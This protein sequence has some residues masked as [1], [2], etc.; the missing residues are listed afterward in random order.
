MK[1]RHPASH[2]WWQNCY[3]ANNR[4]LGADSGVPMGASQ[5]EVYR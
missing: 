2:S 4:A 3:K 1:H 5:R